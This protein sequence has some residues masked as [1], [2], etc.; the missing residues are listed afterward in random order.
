[1]DEA[2]L[3]EIDADMRERAAQGV[4]KDQIPGLQFVAV[5][6]SPTRLISCEFRAASGPQPG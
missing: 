5:M 4:E 6:V 1:V 3:A 2:L